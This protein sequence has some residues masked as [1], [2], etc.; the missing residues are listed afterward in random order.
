MNLKLNH[1]ICFC[2]MLTACF[3][4]ILL[5]YFSGEFMVA[6]YAGNI[7]KN[8]NGKINKNK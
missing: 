5:R 8:I 3:T 2:I 6:G 7:N 1:F 4:A